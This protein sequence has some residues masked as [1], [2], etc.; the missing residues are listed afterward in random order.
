MTLKGSNLHTK[1]ASTFDN[2]PT[3][4][5]FQKKTIYKTQNSPTQSYGVQYLSERSEEPIAT[6]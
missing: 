4:V 3:G 5:E 6:H 1:N 2:N